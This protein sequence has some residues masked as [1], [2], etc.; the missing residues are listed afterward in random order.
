VFECSLVKMTDWL[1]GP[2]LPGAVFLHNTL[3]QWTESL[4]VVFQRLFSLYTPFPPVGAV[5]TQEMLT[6][7]SSLVS[8]KLRYQRERIMTKASSPE[9]AFV[10]SSLARK[11]G[12]HQ[13][14]GSASGT[15]V[16]A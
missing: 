16:L 13:A 6:D 14:S 11:P 9:L 2:L 10:I 8:I 4:A 7:E 12:L 3:V 1:L 15:S 5:L